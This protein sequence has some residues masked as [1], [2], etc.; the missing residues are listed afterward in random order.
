M[1]VHPSP[2]E[3]TDFL[4]GKLPSEKCDEFA[5]HLEVCPPCQE[6]IGRLES[7]SDTLLECVQNPVQA[8]P[9]D[10]ACQRAM[11]KAMTFVGGSADA[12]SITESVAS[13]SGEHDTQQGNAAMAK[14]DK[15]M[16]DFSVSAVSNDAPKIPT[17]AEIIANSKPQTCSPT[18]IGTR[19]NPTS[20]PRPTVW[21]SS[22][23]L[24]S[25]AR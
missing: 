2:D 8:A 21:C 3:L 13:K 9:L 18:T 12:P 20:L 6:T 19:S 10:S 11:K 23:D 7:H 17:T 14:P 15:S 1:A 22:S 4:L 24:S 16:P 5:G 25:V